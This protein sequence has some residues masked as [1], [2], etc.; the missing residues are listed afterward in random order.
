M[1]FEFPPPLTGAGPNVSVLDPAGGP[2]SSIIDTGDPFLVRVEWSVDLPAASLLGGQWLVRCYAESIGPGQEVQIGTQAI[3]VAAGTPGPGAI[4]Y[5]ANIPV[6]AGTLQAE[7]NV[8]SGV[9]TIV[10]VVTH[11]GFLGPT[12]LAGF[13]QGPVIQMR[14]P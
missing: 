14:E 7:S 1:P 2:P 13:D 9:Y 6:A 4:A 3:N 12:V 10:A 8:S 5:T 11:N